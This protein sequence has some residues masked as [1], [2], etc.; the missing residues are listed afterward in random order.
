GGKD[1]GGHYV[2]VGQISLFKRRA[3]VIGAARTLEN[4]KAVKIAVEGV[5]HRITKRIEPGRV[6]LLR[7]AYSSNDKVGAYGLGELAR[8]GKASC[9]LAIHIDGDTCLG[10]ERGRNA[11]G[12]LYRKLPGR[13]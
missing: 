4:F 3:L 1:G 2:L 8:N 13:S 10:I 11:G 5:V 12:T 6:G 9:R 7:I